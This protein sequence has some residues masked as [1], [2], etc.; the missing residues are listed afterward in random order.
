M[1]GD[2]NL[3]ILR[4]RDEIEVLIMRSAAVY[5]AFLRRMP[6]VRGNVQST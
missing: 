4:E 1:T 5:T 3:L 6:N 2:T